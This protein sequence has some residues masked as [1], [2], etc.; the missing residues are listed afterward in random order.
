VRDV[1]ATQPGS[2]PELGV[3]RVR[4]SLYLPLVCAFV[5]PALNRAADADWPQPCFDAAPV[6]QASN[7]AKTA[8][9]RSA[10]A[11]RAQA[12]EA[13]AATW[14]PNWPAVEDLTD[15]ALSSATELLGS[16][17]AC[18]APFLDEAGAAATGS[19]H[20]AQAETLYN[21]R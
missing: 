5:F 8:D 12:E 20:Y 3:S 19:G 9:L 13:A 14:A 17:N 16:E 15:K 4:R 6:E 11:L 18:L 1:G 7:T 21:E 2:A 10:L